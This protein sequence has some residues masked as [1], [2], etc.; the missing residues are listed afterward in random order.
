MWRSGYPGAPGE[1]RKPPHPFPDLMLHIASSGYYFVSL[2]M[3]FNKLVNLRECLPEFCEL[4]EQ[5][6][7]TQGGGGWNPQ[8]VVGRSETQVPAGSLLLASEVE[9]G[10]SCRT[11]PSPCGICSSLWVD[12]VRIDMKS[13]T[14]CWGQGIA[15]C[16]VWRS[17][18]T[19]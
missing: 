7:R 19:L 18:Q 3:S 10:C 5:T 9:V 13:L 1:G 6:K 16:C 8:S 4:P 2:T 14:S 11:E 17:S 15:G 12:S